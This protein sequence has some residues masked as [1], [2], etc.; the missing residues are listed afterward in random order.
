MTA[1]LNLEMQRLG[2]HEVTKKKKEEMWCD[3]GV[4]SIAMT[5]TTK[6]QYRK[7]RW[8]R[9]IRLRGAKNFFFLVQLLTG[10]NKYTKHAEGT[11]I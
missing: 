3:C 1:V 11:L 10:H 5:A 6:I 8:P 4:G 7:K 9:K 2:G